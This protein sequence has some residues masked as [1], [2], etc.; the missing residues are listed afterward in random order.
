MLKQREKEQH[1]KI[2]RRMK[3]GDKKTA[4]RLIERRDRKRKNIK[5]RRRMKEENKETTLRLIERREKK[6]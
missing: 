3:E 4:L 6:H 5:I 2:R 1:F